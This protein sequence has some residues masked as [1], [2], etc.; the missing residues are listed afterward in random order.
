MYKGFC[1]AIDLGL[2]ECLLPLLRDFDSLE[3][4]VTHHNGIPVLRSDTRNELP[5]VLLFKVLLCRNEDFR[6]WIETLKLLA[7]L[8]RQMS[9]N[10]HQSLVRN[11]EPLRLHD[12][13]DHLERLARTNTMREQCAATIKAVR[14]SILLVLVE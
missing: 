10:D 5:P 9:R 13:C 4:L 11:P 8:L 7:C 1:N 6:L 14:H 2:I 3:L 12:G